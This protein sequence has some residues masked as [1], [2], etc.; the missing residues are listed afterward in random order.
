MSS[1]VAFSG[2]GGW[3]TFFQ[4]YLENLHKSSY[5]LLLLHLS[6]FKNCLPIPAVSVHSLKQTC[7]GSKGLQ[8][9]ILT[10]FDFMTYRYFSS[11]PIEERLQGP[12]NHLPSHQKSQEKYKKFLGIAVSR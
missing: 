9:K 4:K 5:L 11:T 2:F 3:A 6:L 8:L 10:G 12:I 1:V 7:N